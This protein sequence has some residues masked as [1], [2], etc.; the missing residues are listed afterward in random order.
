MSDLLEVIIQFKAHPENPEPEDLD[1]I[2][3]RFPPGWRWVEQI[4]KS[5]GVH[6]EVFEGP[7]QG[8]EEF[9]DYIENYFDNLVERKKIKV[10]KKIVK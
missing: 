6:Y 5:S 7:E 8:A 3:K 1:F 4:K 10:L 9:L 2:Y